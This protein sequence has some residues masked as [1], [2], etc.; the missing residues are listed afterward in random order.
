MAFRADAHMFAE[1]LRSV[2]FGDRLS[3]RFSWA[4]LATASALLILGTIFFSAG[5]PPAP[6]E[7][8]IGGGLMGLAVALLLMEARRRSR[9]ISLVLNGPHVGIYRGHMLWQVGHLDDFTA[10]GARFG[11]RAVWANFAAMKLAISSTAV[12]V[13][14]GMLIWVC[15]SIGILGRFALGSTY[16]TAERVVATLMIP[17][18]V[19]F[20]VNLGLAARYRLELAFTRN[21]GAA[22]PFVC[23]IARSDAHRF[24]NS[25]A[26]LLWW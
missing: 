24:P 8:Q 7:W 13:A 4:W 11:L 23:L 22:T 25:E 6:I 10:G 1:D 19:A 18:C 16:T 14:I 5:W 15:F 17:P 9:K 12:G 21:D 20:I 26:A 2:P 3:E